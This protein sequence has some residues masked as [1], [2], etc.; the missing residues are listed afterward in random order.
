M[1]LLAGSGGRIGNTGVPQVRQIRTISP[2]VGA[3]GGLAPQRTPPPPRTLRIAGVC[4]RAP[5]GSAGRA[6]SGALAAV[7]TCTTVRSSS[8]TDLAAFSPVL[9]SAGGCR[10][11]VASWEPEPGNWGA[12]SQALGRRWAGR[13]QGGGG[14]AVRFF[15]N[16]AVARSFCPLSASSRRDANRTRRAQS[17]AR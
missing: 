3:G 15:T 17:G 12:G 5:T 16:S 14:G 9:L 11:A 13:A 2:G 4:R 8:L 7:A 6:A 10:H 1:R